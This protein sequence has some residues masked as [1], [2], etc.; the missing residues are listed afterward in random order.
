MPDLDEMRTS[1][2]LRLWCETTLTIVTRHSLGT[3]GQPMSG[4]AEQLIADLFGGS[5]A[6][7]GQR[8]WDVQA[9][10]GK[11]QVKALWDV[12]RRTRRRLGKVGLDLDLFIA[13][14]FDKHGR[15]AEVWEVDDETLTAVKQTASRVVRLPWVRDHGTLL[16]PKRVGAAARRLGLDVAAAAE[17]EYP[18][19]G[20]TEA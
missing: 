1:E 6:P 18:S 7:S 10:V 19:V 17:Q 3:V 8:D 14:V 13:V 16:K 5:L 12:G 11:I 4:L 20:I 15:V 2:L 9:D